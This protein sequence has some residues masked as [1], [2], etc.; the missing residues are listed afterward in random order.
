MRSRL[1]RSRVPLIRSATCAVASLSIRGRIGL[2]SP[3]IAVL[4]MPCRDGPPG[5]KHGKNALC[6][7]CLCHTMECEPSHYV[8]WQ[9][10]NHRNRHFPMIRENALIPALPHQ[11]KTVE[12]RVV[13]Y[14]DNR[15][16]T[17]GTRRRPGQSPWLGGGVCVGGAFALTAF[18]AVLRVGLLIRLQQVVHFSLRCSCVRPPLCLALPSDPGVVCALEVS[19]FCCFW[20]CALMRSVSVAETDALVS[21]TSLTCGSSNAD[22]AAAS[23]NLASA[24][25]WSALSVDRSASSLEAAF[26]LPFSCEV[27]SS[28]AVTAMRFAYRDARAQAGHRDDADQDARP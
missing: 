1:G 13:W 26:R 28:N 4:R 23:A 6:G 20:S 2:T 25:C 17:A 18:G 9:K 5:E 8:V 11:P 16:R 7:F 27:A 22:H 10:A 19:V 3:P 14:T 24:F 15:N 21:I 12:N